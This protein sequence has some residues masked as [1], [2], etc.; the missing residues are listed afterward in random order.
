MR[1]R[2]GWPQADVFS[3]GVVMY[4]LLVREL[5]IITYFNT[6]KGAKLGMHTPEDYAE[7]VGGGGWRAMCH[8]PRAAL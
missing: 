8:V 5:L 6:S 3:F 1:L 7:M 4:E 2:L